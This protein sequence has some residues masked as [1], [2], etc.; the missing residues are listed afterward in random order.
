ML[1]TAAEKLPEDLIK[2]PSVQSGPGLGNSN[3]RSNSGFSI[4]L[5]RDHIL[6]GHGETGEIWRDLG[7]ARE[8]GGL[9][10][11]LLPRNSE[12]NLYVILCLYDNFPE[13]PFSHAYAYYGR[14][15]VSANMPDNFTRLP[16]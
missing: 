6:S 3:K 2:L 15:F 13:A 10:H 1:Q 11:K 8:A 7:G 4:E 14:L 12:A 5:T 16:T 9:K